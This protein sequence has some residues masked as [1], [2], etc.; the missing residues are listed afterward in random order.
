MTTT[1]ILPSKY[2]AK[3]DIT[4]SRSCSAREF[5]QR[6]K[7]NLMSSSDAAI[8]ANAMLAIA[9][10]EAIE[11][12]EAND[13]MP[14]VLIQ[15][16]SGNGKTRYEAWQDVVSFNQGN[17]APGVSTLPFYLAAG[18]LN[19]GATMA[20]EGF[21]PGSHIEQEELENSSLTFV[22]SNGLGDKSVWVPSVE[23][24]AADDWQLVSE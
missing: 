20:R 18:L 24:F 1:L 15:A 4:D 17:D 11:G 23:D 2:M 13:D 10:L 12:L 5:V 14:G 21:V 9:E 3:L 6:H 8:I 16:M 22:F 19:S 7:D